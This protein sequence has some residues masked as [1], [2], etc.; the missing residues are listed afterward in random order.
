MKLLEQIMDEL[1][2]DTLKSFSIVPSFGGYFRSVK[3]IAE[4]SPEKMVLLQK[5]TSIVLEG[6]NLQVGKYFEEDIFIK[7]N[8]KVIKVE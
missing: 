3:S 8:I 1:G 5:K 2:A 4:Y 6:E 7:G